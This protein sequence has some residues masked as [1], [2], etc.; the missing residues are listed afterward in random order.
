LPPE[1]RTGFAT[2]PDFA[3]GAVLRG[4]AAFD[5]LRGFA[6]TLALPSWRPSL[7]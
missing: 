6:A 5:P 1:R 7:T 2:L 4:F 3:F